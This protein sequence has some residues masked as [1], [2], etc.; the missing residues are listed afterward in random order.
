MTG[1]GADRK[2]SHPRQKRVDVNQEFDTLAELGAYLTNVSKSGAFIRSRDP[3]PVGTR[4]R[5]RFTIFLDDPE[6]FEGLG[7]VVRISDRPRGMGVTFLELTEQSQKLV[8][9]IL[10]SRR[11]RRKRR[12]PAQP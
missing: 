9:R 12:A 6:I 7:E 8:D 10:S 5:M 4:L 2:D 1:G 3:W 11:A